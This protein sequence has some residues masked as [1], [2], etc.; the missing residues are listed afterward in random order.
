MVNLPQAI[1]ETWS[2]PVSLRQ[3]RTYR[4]DLDYFRCFLII[5]SCTG[6]TVLRCKEAKTCSAAFWN[7]ALVL[8]PIAGVPLWVGCVFHFISNVLPNDAPRVLLPLWITVVI[9]RCFQG[10]LCSDSWIH[11][12][13]FEIALLCW[14]CFL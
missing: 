6:T 8:S 11:F 9:W 1:S 10:T 2:I 14:C 5:S 13:G 12:L 4:P 7:T 3:R